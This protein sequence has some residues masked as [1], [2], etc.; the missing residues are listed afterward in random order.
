MIG[1]ADPAIDILGH[2]KYRLEAFETVEGQVPEL[3]VKADLYGYSV[4]HGRTGL[5]IKFIQRVWAVDVTGRLHESRVE[6]FYRKMGYREWS[7]DAPPVL[8][9]RVKAAWYHACG[10]VEGK[11]NVGWRIVTGLR[12]LRLLERPPSW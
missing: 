9:G 7:A 6:W 3:Q 8:R 4:G 5:Q 10:V 2:G 1:P 11:G 12:R